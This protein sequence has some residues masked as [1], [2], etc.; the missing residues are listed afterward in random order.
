MNKIPDNPKMY[1]LHVKFCEGYGEK[2]EKIIELLQKQMRTLQ[3]GKWEVDEE[4]FKQIA[5]CGT[6]LSNYL[7][8]Q[9]DKETE[10]MKKKQILS[11]IIMTLRSIVKRTSVSIIYKIILRKSGFI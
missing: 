11:S 8:A 9:V 10:V 4:R 2:P 1:Q 3:T 7:L 6:K 5:E